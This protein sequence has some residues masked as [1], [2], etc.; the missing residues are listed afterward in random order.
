MQ[1][2]SKR[3]FFVKLYD[4]YPLEDYVDITERTK[5]QRRSIMV[6]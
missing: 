5:R 6:D 1:S 3:F 4:L 2:N